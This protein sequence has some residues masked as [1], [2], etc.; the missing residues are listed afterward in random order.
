MG[1][2]A[3]IDGNCG[4]AV[5]E[6]ADFRAAGDDDAAVDGENVAFVEDAFGAGDA[7][8]DLV[9]DRGAE[10]GGIAVVTLEGGDGAE[11]GD[12]FH[13]DLLE[14]H[15]GG[16]GDNVGRDRVVDLAKG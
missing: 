4:P 3:A 9:V 2:V 5:F 13:G 6:D 8:D 1:A 7:V 14:I 12:F 15:R 10:S 11:F 16:A